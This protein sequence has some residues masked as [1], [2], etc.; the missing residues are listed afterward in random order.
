METSAQ[1]SSQEGQDQGSFMPCGVC[2][3]WLTKP[4]DSTGEDW[5][6]CPR[7]LYPHSRTHAT[8]GCHNGVKS[9]E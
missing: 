7:K 3:L 5:G 6:I 4:D 2:A 8:D 1:N 9:K